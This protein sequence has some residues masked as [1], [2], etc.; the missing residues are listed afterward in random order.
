MRTWFFLNEF[1]P[2]LTTCL[3]QITIHIICC[4]LKNVALNE[5]KQ[6]FHFELILILNK[7]FFV[8][9]RKHFS[10]MFFVK[11]ILVWWHIFRHLL[12]VWYFSRYWKIIS[13]HLCFPSCFR[14]LSLSIYNFF[15]L[16]VKK[17]LPIQKKSKLP[18]EQNIDNR[19]KTS[20]YIIMHKNFLF[21]MMFQRQAIFNIA[22]VWIQYI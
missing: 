22:A 1:E 8:L 7:V 4:P 2:Y 6:N 11:L 3:L 14:S 12:Y 15:M 13:Q 18:R 10:I 5:T 19:Q 17:L 20:Q 16:C 9:S 21:L